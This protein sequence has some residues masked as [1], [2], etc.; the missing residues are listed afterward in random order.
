MT[1]A[2]K[3]TNRGDDVAD[4]QRQLA[5]LGYLAPNLVDGVF[6]TGT[7]AAVIALQKAA[8]LAADGVV[9][10]ATA[11][12][13]ANLTSFLP[14]SVDQATAK[15]GDG[16][17]F[18]V[19]DLYPLDL[20]D[21][22]T[23]QIDIPPFDKIAASPHVAG[24]IL[25]ASEGLAWP[26]AY[27]AWTKASLKAARRPGW[28]VGAYHYLQAGLDGAKQADFYVDACARS[29][30]DLA[31]DQDAIVPIV[32]VELGG[33]RSANRRASASQFVTCASAFAERAR[34]LT[35]RGV[36]LYG[37]GAMR[38]LAIVDRMG[39]DRVWNPSYTPTMALSGISAVDGR[40]GPWA[41]SD[42]VLWQ[43]GGDGVGVDRAHHLPLATAGLKIDVSV[44]VHPGGSTRESFVADLTAATR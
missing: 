1:R 10:P 27:R 6:G 28:L 44:H 15:N 5:Q 2:L 35:G 32:D 11:A 40:P 4:L 33:E 30:L 34:K 8:G 39:C 14:P 37:R 17:P 12:A 20:D 23:P 19:V 31:N 9:G 42:V 25:K 26:D 7:A 41:P 24:A 22:R 13:I 16:A 36:M 29:G 38:D 3:I 18:L 43:Y 21:P